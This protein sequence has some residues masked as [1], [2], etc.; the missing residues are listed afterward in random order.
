MPTYEYR[1]A[2]GHEFEVFQKMSDEPI[3]RCP[4]CGAAAERKISSGAGLVFKGSGFYVTDYKK[5]GEKKGKSADE[6][7]TA[8][9]SGD[10]SGSSGDK[11]G[12]GGAGQGAAGSRS[13][14]GAGG[15]AGSSTSE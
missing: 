2:E 14:G 7:A 5:A 6:G 8:A 12:A 4:E 10:G 13:E 1:C 11:P 15:T 3:T 9:G